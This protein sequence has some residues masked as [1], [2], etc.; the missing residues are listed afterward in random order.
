V[1]LPGADINDHGVVAISY[2]G[3]AKGLVFW[4]LFGPDTDD[5][6]TFEVIGDKGKVLLTRHLG[7]IDIVSSYGEYH[8]CLDTKPD[9]FEKSHFGADHRLVQELE[10]YC[11]S[12]TSPVT[13]REGLGA[14]RL[15]HASH[16]SLR[17]GGERILMK[18][19]EGQELS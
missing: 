10:R 3:G 13:A 15:V 11:K 4:T 7:Q 16:L 14:A 2:T 17:S 8:E 5:Q 12:G 6:E 1:W 19:I 9:G 18:D